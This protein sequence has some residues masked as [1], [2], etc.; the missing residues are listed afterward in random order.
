VSQTARHGRDLTGSHYQLL[1]ALAPPALVAR[2]YA[3]AEAAGYLA[4][5]FGDSC[6][7]L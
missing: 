2:A 5:E 6:L 7:I 4:H 3:H 1:H